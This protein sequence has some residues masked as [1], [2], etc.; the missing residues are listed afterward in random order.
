MNLPE[1]RAKV[2][3]DRERT[4]VISFNAL[5]DAEEV[6]GVSL[7]SGS[8]D[9]SSLRAIRAVLWAGLRHE[10]RS[11]TL[12]DVGAM[13]A[14]APG[15]MIGAMEAVGEALNKA[16]PDMPQTGDAASAE[17]NANGSP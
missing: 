4:I 11:L 1:V 7:L 3:L 2:T 6:L 8:V 16:L 12:E 14:A 5:C 10:D 9:L 17:G 15:G 13:I